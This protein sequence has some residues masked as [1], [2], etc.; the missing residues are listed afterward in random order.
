M[1]SRLFPIAF[2]MG[3][4]AVASASA[5]TVG[6]TTTVKPGAFRNSAALGVGAPVATD[7][8]VNTDVQGRTNLRFLDQSTLDIGPGSDVRIDRF[9]YNPNRSAAGGTISLVKGVLRYNSRGAPDGAVQ[10]RTP[11]STLGIRGTTIASAYNPVTNESWH[12]ISEGE[13]EVCPTN[14][15]GAQPPPP[16]IVSKDGRRA[17]SGCAIINPRGNNTAVV[18]AAGNIRVFNSPIAGDMTLGLGQQAG[19]ISPGGLSTIAGIQPIAPI[20]V[21][22][23]PVV[24]GGTII[25]GII[26]AVIVTSNND[27]NRRPPPISP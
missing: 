2:A 13:A 15:R 26:A 24:V 27:D 9:V 1:V 11:T 12:Q 20:G 19:V 4:F 3:F 10:I 25:A 14:V 6:R 21:G 7:D 8:L 17:R 22:I 18:D 5:Q 16:P 23:A